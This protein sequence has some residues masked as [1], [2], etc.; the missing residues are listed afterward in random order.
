MPEQPQ[1]TA[2]HVVI[3]TAAGEFIT[4]AFSEAPALAARLRELVDRDVSVACFQG[5]QLKISKPPYRYLMTPDA[6]IPL[7][8]VP[9]NIEPDD[10]G[11]LGVDPAYLEGP[12]QV[13]APAVPRAQPQEDEFFSDQTDEIHNIFDDALPDP[14]A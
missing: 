5:A 14:D 13:T 12:P 10:T 6:N 8:A 2:F 3:L 1:D 9:E 7:W 4:E 11:Y